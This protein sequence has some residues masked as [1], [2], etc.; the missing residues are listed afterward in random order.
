MSNEFDCDKLVEFGGHINLSRQWAY[1]LLGCM[2]YVRRKVT[3]SKSKHFAQLKETFLNNIAAVVGMEEVTPELVLNW[4]Q[5]G[6]Q[7]LL[8]LWTR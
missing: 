4:D 2:N 7:H 5:T 6:N 1:Q 3:T 8:G